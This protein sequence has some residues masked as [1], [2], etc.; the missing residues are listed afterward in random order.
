MS[1]SHMIMLF[2]ICNFIFLFMYIYTHVYMCIFL[3]ILFFKCMLGG[4]L[5]VCAY[6]FEQAILQGMPK[7]RQTLLFSATQTNSVQDLARLSLNNPATISADIESS[8][9]PDKLVQAYITCP[10]ESKLNI[11]YSFIKT[12]LT[13]KVSF[14]YIY[15]YV[16]FFRGG[17]LAGF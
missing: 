11:L 10:L 1:I 4:G 17:G 15:V 13:D 14:M 12:H 7:V 16:S 8:A 9:T 3:Y 5:W 2:V 6:V